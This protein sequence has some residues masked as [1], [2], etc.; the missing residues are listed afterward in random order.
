MGSPL[1]SCVSSSQL[2]GPFTPLATS[3]DI[4]WARSTMVP[5]TWCTTLL[6]SSTRLDF[7]LPSGHLPRRTLRAS[8]GAGESHEFKDVQLFACVVLEH[9]LIGLKRAKK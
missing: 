7:A 8:K 9:I 4:C 5:S 1:A 6:I 2:V 3:S